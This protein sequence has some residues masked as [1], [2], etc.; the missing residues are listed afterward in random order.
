MVGI[1]LK[2]ANFSGKGGTHFELRLTYTLGDYAPA[3]NTRTITKFLYFV[4][5]DG[6]SGYGDSFTGYID[7]V[8]VGS[9]NSIG[10][11]QELLVGEKTDTIEYESNGTKS[12]SYSALIHTPW[13]LGNASVS[14][15]LQLP[16]VDRI[17]TIN[18]ND[19]YVGDIESTINVGINKYVPTY[20]NKLIVYNLH[21][22]KILRTV[23]P[24]SD[25]YKLKFTEEELDFL[26]NEYKNIQ[27][28]YFV[29]RLQTYNGTTLV[30][31]DEKALYGSISDASPTMSVTYAETDSKINSLLGNEASNYVV[32]GLSKPK[33]VVTPTFKKKATFKNLTFS[34]SD[35]SVVTKLAEP[36]EALF[37]N[38][39]GSKFNVLLND[40]R[41]NSTDK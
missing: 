4:S 39:S 14:G 34:C 32:K 22:D 27:N 13:T 15:T 26:Y 35:G 28:V 19:F 29:L 10:K 7:D 16:Q 24:V 8:V 30:G 11:N 12:I 33:I 1:L 40:S 21:R 5:K 6:Y 9:G 20:S 37:N 25:G 18:I 41:N 31:T 17:S 2:S 23:D 36:Y 3:T 38:V